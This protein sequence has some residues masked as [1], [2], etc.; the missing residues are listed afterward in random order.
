VTQINADPQYA[1]TILNTDPSRYMAKA[2][3][4]TLLATREESYILYLSRQFP[5]H[6]NTGFCVSQKVRFYFY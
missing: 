2:L 1:T 6:G 5:F 4:E 3:Y